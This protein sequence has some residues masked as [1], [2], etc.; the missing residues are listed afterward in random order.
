MEPTH[1]VV[2]NSVDLGGLSQPCG[3]LGRR[4]GRR[5]AGGVGVR[6]ELAQHRQTG[7]RVLDD[8]VALGN[9]GFSDLAKK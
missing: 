8:L 7:A 3:R 1:Q 9:L 6:L 4:F 5:L 2:D